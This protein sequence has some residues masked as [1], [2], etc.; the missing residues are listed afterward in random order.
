MK[1]LPTLERVNELLSYDRDSG[2]FTWKEGRNNNVQAGDE[3]GCLGSD[4]YRQIGI[5]GQ[6]EKA[7]RL[8]WLVVYG[9]WPAGQIDHIDGDRANNRVDNLR[10]VSGSENQWNLNRPWGAVGMVGVTRHGDR[11]RSSISAKGVKRDLGMFDT[12]ETAR[13]AYLAA[14]RDLHPSAPAHHHQDQSEAS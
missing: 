12:A 3:A 6:P 13:S 1:Q 14:K 10:D 8:V 9:V 11:F 4:G 5:D 7:H 2:G